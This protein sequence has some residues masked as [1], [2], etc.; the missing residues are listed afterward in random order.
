MTLTVIVVV[1]DD[2]DNGNN[3]NNHNNNA[4]IVMTS[5]LIMGEESTPEQCPHNV[6][7]ITTDYR[8][9]ACAFTCGADEQEG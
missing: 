9:T 6:S 5:Y 1:D 8:E 4:S 3:K 2:S 7:I